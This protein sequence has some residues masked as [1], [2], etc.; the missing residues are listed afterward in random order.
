LKQLHLLWGIVALGMV[1]FSAVV[2]ARVLDVQSPVGNGLSIFV[3]SMSGRNNGGF[4]EA[5]SSYDC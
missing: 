1:F 2:K 5:F 3:F 4:D